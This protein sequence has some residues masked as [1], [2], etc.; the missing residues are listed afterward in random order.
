VSG[1]IRE[2]HWPRRKPTPSFKASFHFQKMFPLFPKRGG[3]TPK[4]KREVCGRSVVGV[5]WHTLSVTWRGKEGR[6]S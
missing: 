3:A 6:T 5:C 2:A 1:H 4:G